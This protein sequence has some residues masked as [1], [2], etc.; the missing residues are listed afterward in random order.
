MQTGEEKFF[1]S[2]MKIN[3]PGTLESLYEEWK[4]GGYGY[5]KWG[6][7]QRLPIYNMHV[8]FKGFYSLETDQPAKKKKKSSLMVW[9]TGP[10]Q[11]RNRKPPQNDNWLVMGSKMIF[12]DLSLPF[13]F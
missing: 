5:Q 13:V 8:C 3:V 9:R 6:Y 10:K 12:R 7:A 11:T 4:G 1:F 2:V